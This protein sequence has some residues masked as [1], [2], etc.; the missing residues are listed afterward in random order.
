LQLVTRSQLVRLNQ[1]NLI[2]DNAELTKTGIIIVDIYGK[3][4]ERE[5]RK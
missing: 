3:I 5:R 1:N 2:R 4:G